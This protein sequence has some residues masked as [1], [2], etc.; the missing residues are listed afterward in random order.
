MFIFYNIISIIILIKITQSVYFN[1][2]VSLY[3]HNNN[4]VFSMV[5]S[6]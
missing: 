5:L 2:S 3:N 4:N 1:A 6:Q